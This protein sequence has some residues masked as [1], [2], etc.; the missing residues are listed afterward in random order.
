[1][2]NG[3]AVSDLND[4]PVYSDVPTQPDVATA[5]SRPWAVPGSDQ[6][7]RVLVNGVVDYAIYMID[8]EGRV[9]TWNSGAQ[10]IKGYT[11]DEIIGSHFSRFY[12]E[13]DKAAGVPERAM[14]TAA[15]TGRFETEGWRV[16]KDG[17]RFRANVVL[18]AIRNEAGELIAYAKVTRDMSDRVGAQTALRESEERFRIL[19]QGVA[20]YAIYMLDPD[21]RI[22]N[23]NRGGERIK[24]Y[25]ADEIVGRHFSIFFT[26]EDR[27][28]GEPAREIATASREGR[29]EGEG[30]R[31]R[32][33]GTRFWAGVVVDRI[34][35]QGG[36]LLGFAKVT[37]DMT[38]KKKAEE[39]LE[40]ARAALAQAQKMEAIGQLT[41]G[42]A[43]D[44]NNLLTVIANSLELLSDSARD[45]A[46]K[47]RIIDIAQRATERGA[48]LNQQLLAF[49]RRQPL[50]PE[51][52]DVNALIGGF[53][54][55]LR[56]ACREAIDFGLD[57]SSA[58]VTAK[59]DAQQFETA[60]LNLVVNA[61]DAMP[62]GGSLCIST[63]IETTDTASVKA[64]SEL[65]SGRYVKI[66]VSDNGEGMGPE[67]VRR[68]FEPFFT[69]K[70]VGKG[71]GL[72]LSQVYGFV[73]QSGGHVAID[74]APGVGTTVTLYLPATELKP[75]DNPAHPET[76]VKARTARILVVE[77]DPDVLDVA[78]ESLRMMG[79]D[80]VTAPDGPSALSVLRR[81]PDIQIMLSDVV[82]PNGMNGVE[83]AREAVRLRPDLR[84]LLASG[85]PMS[86]L[87]IDDGSP[88]FDEFPF[89]S[90]PYHSSQ[91]AQ[92]LR[93]L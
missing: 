41:G 26:E 24:G 91:L 80:V 92:A 45:E 49:S 39:E 88:V 43:H 18:D 76:G 6:L 75:V 59:I 58:P 15:E 47:R 84:V 30:W 28:K 29:F 72:G 53:E 32:K 87:P 27:A 40:R 19:V 62:A 7:F 65:A 16:R 81:D 4:I 60:L 69:T 2:A 52:H 79:Y 44:F 55:V 14:R 23:W 34:L 67:T 73:A 57:L 71:S 50:R 13:E 1:M 37:R 46:Q 77:D 68:A 70:E 17:S 93:A 8:L 63:R 22:T 36:R 12:T 66:A 82:M 56:R 61:R 42:V 83:L 86:A 38:E 9:T 51:P 78:V 10:R 35:D 3:I 90:K 74:S 31:V 54:P 48:K 11:E 5:A 33:D 21:G 64:M 25:P 20:D 85:Y 89:L